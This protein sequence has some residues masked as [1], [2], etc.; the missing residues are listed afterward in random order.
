MK[1][2]KRDHAL[3]YQV[4]LTSEME[5]D[6][7][8]IAEKYIIANSIVLDV[9]SACGDFGVFL[10]KH[11]NCEVHGMEL[12]SASI[13]VARE[14]QAYSMLHQVDLN[15]FDESEFASYYGYF[16]RIALID[17]LE[18]VMRPD[19]VLRKLSRF[20][21]KDGFFV[22]SLPNIA[23]GEIK[24]QLLTNNF[25]YT[26]TGILD[27]THLK[28]FT[29]RTIADFLAELGVE[30]VDCSFK[31]AGISS[32]GFEVSYSVKRCVLKDPHSYIYQYVLMA[33]PSSLGSVIVSQNNLNKMSADCAGFSKRLRRLKL[34]CMV[35]RFLPP[36]SVRR[37][38]A[39]KCYR[40][41]KGWETK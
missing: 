24:L 26:E 15:N 27:K 14:T 29:Y 32:R 4:N 17:I 16:D 35:D 22:I 38:I 23:F 21:K 1:K 7:R 37:G 3:I 12:S 33:R 36:G 40:I 2:P 25:S 39:K 19:A 10:H 5:N 41:A 6:A 8:I 28:F 13:E 31:I 30:I 34:I 20:L 11:K 18:H 9:G